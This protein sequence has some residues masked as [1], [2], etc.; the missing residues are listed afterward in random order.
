MRPAKT[1]SSLDGA[2]LMWGLGG[3][4]TLL[5]GTG[6]DLLDGGSGNDRLEGEAG[7]DL[8]RYTGATRVTVDLRGDGSTDTDSAVQGTARDRL[9][10]IEGAIGGSGGDRFFGDGSAN[11]FQGGLGADTHT[12]GGGRD[13]FDF[14]AV[15]ESLSGAGR[16]VITDFAHLLD[17][18][19]LSGI[20]ANLSIAGDQA[21]RWVGTAA[22]GT[23][24][25]A[26]GYYLSGGNTIIRASNDTDSTAELE[27]QLT[28]TKTL[29]TDDFY[30]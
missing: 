3:N 18:I 9:S 7:V 16:N 30:L 6:S 14:D 4:D 28:G 8:V 20:D 27:I 13:L 26:V 29:S 11:L 25:G 21:F 19:D 15:A 23:T 2:D 1:I 12:G 5:G 24:P 17:D 22:L 10:G